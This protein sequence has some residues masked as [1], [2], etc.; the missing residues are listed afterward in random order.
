MDTS[1]TEIERA[2]DA[3][4]YR[5]LR[6]LIC[7]TQAEQDEAAAVMEQAIGDAEAT[8][9]LVDKA[10]DAVLVRFIGRL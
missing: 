10:V 8:F 9:A 2:A 5:L 3:R 4:R 6:A 1:Q 7:G